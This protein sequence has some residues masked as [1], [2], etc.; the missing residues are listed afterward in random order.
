MNKLDNTFNANIAKSCI[1]SCS[2]CCK[3]GKLFLPKV[4]YERMRA[5]LITNSPEEL[6]AFEE[7]IEKHDGYYIYDQKKSCGFLD[8]KDLCRLHVDGVK[9]TECFAWP[10]H[11]Y[12]DEK[13]A[14]EIRYS[15]TCCNAYHEIETRRHESIRYARQLLA[16]YDED[17]IRSFRNVYNGSYGSKHLCTWKAKI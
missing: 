13:Q 2:S 5:W 3:K 10:F 14:L 11:V 12:L 1:S 4:E 8:E 15:D 16:D 7:R 6:E 17:L 9:P